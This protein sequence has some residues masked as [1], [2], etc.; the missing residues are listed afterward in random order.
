M[1]AIHDPELARLR[2]LLEADLDADLAAPDQALLVKLDAL[3]RAC[4]P[5]GQAAAYLAGMVA[6]LV[7]V[8]PLLT[9]ATLHQMQHQHQ[10]TK[11]YHA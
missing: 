11:E 9:A 6:M 4:T 10:P 3:R 1:N 8:A 7:Q 2:A 5:G